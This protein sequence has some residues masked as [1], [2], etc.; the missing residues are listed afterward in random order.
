M[1]EPLM[2][3]PLMPE[4]LM[5]EPEPEGAM[6]VDEVMEISPDPSEHRGLFSPHTPSQPSTQE[7]RELEESPPSSTIVISD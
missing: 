2:P 7:I 1:P 6:D 3:E 4:P 5:P